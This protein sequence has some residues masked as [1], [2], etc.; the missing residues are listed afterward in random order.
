MSEELQ[1]LIEVAKYQKGYVA[2]YQ[3][4]VSNQLLRHHE[5]AGRIERVLR[6]VYRLTQYPT[7]EDEQLLIAYLW[8]KEQGTISHESALAIHDLSDVLPKKVHLTL[9]EEQSRVRRKM[10][11]WLELHFADISEDEK[12]WYDVVPVTQPVRTLVD[13]A[14]DRLEPELLRQAVEDAKKK[15][16]VAEDFEWEL[17][18]RLQARCS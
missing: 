6:G 9:P 14:A 16:L 5:Q 15:R 3:V 12:Q 11:E 10:P 2:S 7:E 8:S 18:T 1:K 17:I 4:E 13:V